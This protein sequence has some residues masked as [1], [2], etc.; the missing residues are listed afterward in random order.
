[1]VFTIYSL[2][3][4]KIADRPMVGQNREYHG[5]SSS[6]RRRR[7]RSISAGRKEELEL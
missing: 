7:G 3:C 5:M 4:Q 6:Q 1:M 2:P